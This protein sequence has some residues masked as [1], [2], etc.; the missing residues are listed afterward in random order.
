MWVY[1][2]GIIDRLGEYKPLLKRICA[3][4]IPL[5]IAAN[6]GVVFAQHHDK[7]AHPILWGF[8]ANAFDLPAAH[9]LSL[10]YAAGLAV[11]IQNRRVA[12]AG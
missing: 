7:A 3:V 10:G 12:C 2:S 1:R 9:L 11:L 5:G 4:C 6:I 8:L